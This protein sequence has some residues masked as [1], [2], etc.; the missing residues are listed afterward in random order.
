[1]GAIANGDVSISVAGAIRWTGAATTPRHTVLEFIQFM[2]DKQDDGVAAGD[3]VLDITVDT[4]FDRS[5]DQI[6]AL[7]S[8][9]NIDDTFALHLY[10]G[11]VSQID[12]DNGEQTLYG[13]LNVIGPVESGTEYIDRK[14]VV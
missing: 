11:S 8:P 10:D 6:V 4:P 5:T 9:F 14:S 13:G 3:I 2:M 7:N 12:Q 1:M